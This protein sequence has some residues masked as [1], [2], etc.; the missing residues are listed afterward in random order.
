MVERNADLPHRLVIVG[1][2]GWLGTAERVAREPARALGDRIVFTGPVPADRLLALYRGADLFAL[3][4]LHEGF[5]LPVLEAMAQA[6][7]VVCSD[8]PV[9]HEVA[10]DAARFVPARGPR[11]VGDRA[12]RPAPRRG[13]RGPRLAPPV[14]CTP[15]ASPGTA[16]PSAPV[17]STAASSARNRAR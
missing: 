17:P 6:T 10:G 4:S 12:R 9:L 7:P 13:R 2:T 16:A 3:P 11:R 15:T 1:P 5:G 14:A 8:I